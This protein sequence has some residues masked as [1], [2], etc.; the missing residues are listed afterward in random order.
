MPH[1]ESWVDDLADGGA[2]EVAAVM[3]SHGAAKS[4]RRLAR[5]AGF[6]PAVLEHRPAVQHHWQDLHSLLDV[7]QWPNNPSLRRKL[8][9][10]LSKVH[11]PDKPG[12]SHDRFEC[13]RRAYSLA[14]LHYDSDGTTR[15]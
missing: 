1:G 12:G 2:L 9:Y 14:N 13:L 6:M 15:P 3:V 10:R 8:Y 5:T 11:H 4:L 7:E